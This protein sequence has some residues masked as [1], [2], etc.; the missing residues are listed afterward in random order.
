MSVTR[1][2]ARIKDQRLDLINI[3]LIASGTQEVLHIECEFDDLWAG[4]TKTAVFYRT[5]EEVYHVLL[6]TDEDG[7][8]VAVVPHEV[9]AEDGSFFFGL[10]GMA[11]N[12][13]TTEVVCLRV[14]QGAIRESTATPKDPTPD[15]YQQ[16]LEAYARMEGRLDE[17]IVAHGSSV[18]VQH[19][20]SDEYISGLIRTNGV[21]AEISFTIRNMSLVAGGHHYTDYCIP[22]ALVPLVEVDLQSSN[23]DLDIVLEVADE[24]NGWAQ[25]L[26]ENSSSNYY[27]TDMVTRVKGIYPLEKVAVNRIL[28]V[29]EIKA[30]LV[31]PAVISSITLPASAWVGTGKLYSQ[32]APLAGITENSQVDLTPSVEQ[33][34]VFYEKDVTFV[35]END[36]G[37]LTVY[38]IGQKP[39]ND[40]TIQVTITEVSV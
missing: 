29:E 15:I 18:P 11:E 19:T 8:T 33:L 38:V 28:G 3:P 30:A 10:I 9:L 31:P 1:F 2:L 14:V 13:R 37:V 39:T 4:Y 23:P 35:T 17:V 5:A 12:V 7:H 26:I 22:P 36:D 20:L 6:T 40:Y 25:I 27:D 16:V 24:E 34:V 32:V 21:M